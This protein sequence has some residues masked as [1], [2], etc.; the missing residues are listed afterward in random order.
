MKGCEIQWSQR[1]SA[2]GGSRYET[3]WR[4]L[5]ELPT[6]IFWRVDSD[7]AHRYWVEVA[8]TAKWVVPRNNIFR[9]N[10]G[11]KIFILY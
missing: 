7:G 1:E 4:N 6:E 9:P 3:V 2:V 8:E 11:G 10:M 5:P